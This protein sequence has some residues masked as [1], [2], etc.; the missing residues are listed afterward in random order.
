LLDEPTC[1]LD[2]EAKEELASLIR[3]LASEGV[4][5]LTV[6]HDCEFAAECSDRVIMMFDGRAAGSGAPGEF[7]CEADFYTTDIRRITSPFAGG[8]VT[9][10]DALSAFEAKDSGEGGEP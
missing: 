3:K 7:F 6:T 9:L 2:G 1:G 4:A 10:S 5:V 8:C